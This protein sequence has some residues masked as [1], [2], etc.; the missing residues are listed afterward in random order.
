MPFSYCGEVYRGKGTFKSKGNADGTAT[1]DVE[2]EYQ[3]AGK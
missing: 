3:T 1:T 2:G